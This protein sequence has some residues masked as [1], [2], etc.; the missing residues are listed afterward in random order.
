MNWAVVGPLVDQLRHVA[1]GAEVT[2]C[3]DNPDFNDLPNC[4]I[5]AANPATKWEQRSY[6]ADTVEEALRAALADYGMWELI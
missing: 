4:V 5:Y 2:L 1:E 6:R 3:H